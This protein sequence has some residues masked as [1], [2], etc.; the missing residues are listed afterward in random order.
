VEAG[1]QLLEAGGAILHQR[2]GTGEGGGLPP[3]EAIEEWLNG[4]D[5][6]QSQTW[7]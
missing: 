2:N 1:E 6:N 4:H 5:L 3:G 7:E